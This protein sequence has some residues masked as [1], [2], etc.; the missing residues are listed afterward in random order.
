MNKNKIEALSKAQSHIG[1]HTANGITYDTVD[2]AKARLN[3]F[4]ISID[5]IETIGSVALVV[6][7]LYMP[8]DAVLPVDSVKGSISLTIDVKYDADVN[9]VAEPK[10]GIEYE[11]KEY[12]SQKYN[13]LHFKNWMLC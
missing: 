13:P 9:A 1:I 8:K 3:H 7:A 5:E 6:A 4:E 12:L 11:V 2:L 10:E